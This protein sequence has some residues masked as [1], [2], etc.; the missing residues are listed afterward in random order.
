MSGADRRAVL[1]ANI[2]TSI[3]R[4]RKSVSGFTQESGILLTVAIMV[5]Y[6]VLGVLYESYVIAD[7]SLRAPSAGFG[8]LAHAAGI[9]RDLSIYASWTDH[10]GRM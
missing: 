10:A 5:V 7:D 4:H 9:S 6:I 8:A 1:P 2:T 3:S